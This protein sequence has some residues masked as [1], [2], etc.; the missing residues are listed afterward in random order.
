MEPSYI[1]WQLTI[2]G[3]FCF[4]LMIWFNEHLGKM[5]LRGYKEI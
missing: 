2:L 1:L 3:Y 4:V 5:G